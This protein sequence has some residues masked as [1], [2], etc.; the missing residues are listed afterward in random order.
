MN[1]FTYCN[2]VK[3]VFGNGVLAKAFGAADM[4]A[5]ILWRAQ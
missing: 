3:V 2:P 5:E 1:S 4:L